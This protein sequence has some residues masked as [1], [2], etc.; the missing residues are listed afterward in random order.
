MSD[1]NVILLMNNF[2]AHKLAIK[3][4]KKAGGLQNTKI[5]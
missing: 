4:I 2:S 1:R 3:N 5:I